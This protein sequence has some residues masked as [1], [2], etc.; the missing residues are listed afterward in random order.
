MRRL[1]IN[2]I[3]FLIGMVAYSILFISI[4]EAAQVDTGK[5][6]II[7]TQG[8]AA[9]PCRMVLFQLNS[10]GAQAWFRIPVVSGG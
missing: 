5:G 2:R 1:P 4:A 10:T 8:H 6:K 9:A 3:K 7:V